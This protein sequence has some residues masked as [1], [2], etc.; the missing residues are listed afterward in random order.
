MV[1]QMAQWGITCDSARWNNYVADLRTWLESSSGPTSIPLRLEGL[2]PNG[3]YPKVLTATPC[4]T[5]DGKHGWAYGPVLNIDDSLLVA[6]S[7]FQDSECP[8]L[9]FLERTSK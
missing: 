7:E 2:D 5:T 9:Y 6:N 1:K 8:K 3:V 4:T